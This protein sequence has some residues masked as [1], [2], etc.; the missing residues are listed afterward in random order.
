ME[1]PYYFFSKD[2]ARYTGPYVNGVE[3]GP[4]I[5]SYADG[6]ILVCTIK[7]GSLYQTAFF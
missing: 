4:G 3:E 2:G 7:N 1:K 5:I 6:N